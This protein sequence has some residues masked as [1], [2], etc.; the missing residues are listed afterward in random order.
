M[1]TDNELLEIS[2]TF[3][4]VAGWHGLNEETAHVL[5]VALTEALARKESA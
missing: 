2:G 1:F 3:M 5:A 4:E